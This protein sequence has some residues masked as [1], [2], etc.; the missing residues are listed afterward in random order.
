[1]TKKKRRARRARQWVTLIGEHAPVVSAAEEAALKPYWLERV[2]TD[3]LDGIA[4]A[5]RLAAEERERLL[6]ERG[7]GP[8]RPDGRPEPSGPT[9]T[10][11]E[12]RPIRRKPRLWYG[13]PTE[14]NEV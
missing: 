6:Y 10:E 14:G 8:G 12:P 2:S 11:Q 7:V 1:M 3:L 5:Q 4:H 13:Q 9:R